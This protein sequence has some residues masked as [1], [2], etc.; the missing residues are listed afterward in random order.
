MT[1][2]VCETVAAV[3]L[4]GDNDGL[5]RHRRNEKLLQELTYCV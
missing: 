3:A 5:T 4:V 1:T 2:I